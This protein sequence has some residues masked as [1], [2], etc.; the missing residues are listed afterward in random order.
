MRSDRRVRCPAGL[1]ATCKEAA[2]SHRD[3]APSFDLGF[4]LRALPSPQ[5]NDVAWRHLRRH[6][7]VYLIGGLRERRLSERHLTI[8]GADLS[9]PE[10]S[11]H[12]DRRPCGGGTEA[13]VV[14]PEVVEAQLGH[15]RRDTDAMPDLLEP[16]DRPRAVAR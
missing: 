16:H 6:S 9:V 13:A 4:A 1:C 7:V 12:M 10:E 3:A 2:L 11:L 15:V 14:V 8:S 5:A